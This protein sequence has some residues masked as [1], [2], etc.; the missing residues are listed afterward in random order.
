M[1]CSNDWT[2]ADNKQTTSQD[3][4]MDIGDGLMDIVKSEDI[5]SSFNNEI[6]PA[7]KDCV[8]SEIIFAALIHKLLF[9]IHLLTNNIFFLLFFFFHIR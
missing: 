4:D 3:V 1:D 9:I 2:T 5:S 8:A 7:G 6:I